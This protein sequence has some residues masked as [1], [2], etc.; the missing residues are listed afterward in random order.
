MCILQMQVKCADKYFE[1][2][3]DEAESAELMVEIV[4]SNALLSLFEK[5]EVDEVTIHFPSNAREGQQQCS[6]HIRVRCFG[7]SFALLPDKEDDMKQR[8]IKTLSPSLKELLGSVDIDS[9]TFSPSP[10]NYEHKPALSQKL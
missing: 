9:I 8:L 3:P 7:K 5:V 2:L 10:W 1:I 4:V 6:F